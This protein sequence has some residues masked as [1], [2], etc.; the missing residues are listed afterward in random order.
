[1]A[2]LKGIK[3]N[4]L[5]SEAGGLVK[6]SVK[7]GK[8]A[9]VREA[10][11]LAEAAYEQVMGTQK[12]PLPP[13]VEPN[14]QKKEEQEEER[15]RQLQATLRNVA[16]WQKEEVERIKEERERLAQIREEALVD[17]KEEEEKESPGWNPI[18]WFQSVGKKV[19]G[20]IF[21]RKKKEIKPGG[22]RG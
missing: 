4:G 3:G 16:R 13:A 15:K 12:A 17:K 21:E 2:G 19:K 1:M 9:T 5:I 6:S 8:K 11:K 22:F 18:D 20:W 7:K 14:G 10:G